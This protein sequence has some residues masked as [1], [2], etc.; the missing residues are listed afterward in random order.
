M[1]L[2]INNCHVGN[3]FIGQVIFDDETPEIELFRTQARKYGF[4]EDEYLADPAKVPRFNWNTANTEMAFYS[5]VAKMI[6]EF[7]FTSIK[8]SRTLNEWKNAEGKIR[9]LLNEKELI[10][11]EIDGTVQIDR[12]GGTKFS[13]SIT[14]L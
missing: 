7:S 14:T 13:M 4:D 8:L 2:V 3:I 12:E 9:D 6:P 10:L 5:K 11:K 1:P